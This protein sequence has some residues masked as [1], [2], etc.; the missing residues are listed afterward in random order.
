M[1]LDTH[2]AVWRLAERIASHAERAVF[3]A[4]MASVDGKGPI[5]SAEQWQTARELRRLAN[6]LFESAMQIAKRSPDLPPTA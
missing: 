4:A 5:P 3:D 2:M 6:E 1:H